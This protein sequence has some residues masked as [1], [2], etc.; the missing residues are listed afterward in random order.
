MHSEKE[1]SR[2]PFEGDP[3]RR[4]AETLGERLLPDHPSE[5]ACE[6]AVSFTAYQHRVAAARK[7]SLPWTELG[8]KPLA[9]RLGVDTEVSGRARGVAFSRFDPDRIYLA[10]A[11]GG[12][13]RSDDRG[14][15]WVFTMETFD[16]N[17]LHPGADSLSC[18]ALAVAPQ[19]PDRVYV[20]TGEASTGVSLGIGPLVSYVGG[21]PSSGQDVVWQVEPSLPSLEGQG[22]FQ[23]AV[24]PDDVDL[25]VGAT[26]GGLYQRAVDAGSAS[27]HRV[28]PGPFTSVV[29]GR[30]RDGTVVFLAAAQGGGVFAADSNNVADPDAWS[31]L[32]T[33]F[34]TDN[35]GRISL[36]LAG[37]EVDTVFALAA[38]EPGGFHGVYRLLLADGNWRRLA[39]A[40]QELFTG[41]G[42]WAQA[43]TLDPSDPDVFYLGGSTV[44]IDGFDLGALYRCQLGSDGETMSFTFIGYGVH[45]DIQA[46]AFTP[47]PAKHLW[48]AC[49]GGVFV[50]E[51][52]AAVGQVFASRN[53]TLG[54]IT[55]NHLAQHPTGDELYCGSHDNGLVR[56]RGDQRWETV[57]PSDCSHAVVHWADPGRV[58]AAV[59]E[60]RLALHREGQPT[61]FNL[62]LPLERDEA[63]PFNV[64]LAGTP[65]P[66]S[67]TPA[68]L[69]QADRVAA[70]SIRPWISEQFGKDGS[71]V[72]IPTLTLEGDE[73]DSLICSLRFASHLILYAG[74][75]FGGVYRFDFDPQSESW[76]RKAL[77]AP[78]AP[79]YFRAPITDI[80]ADPADP[81]G[82]SIYVTL[83]GS[84]EVA[85]RPD[86]RRL[87]HYD[88]TTGTWQP[89]SG[90]EQDPGHQL[91]PVRHHAVAVDPQQ[92]QRL[93]VGADIGVWV[94]EDGGAHWEPC[95]TALPDASVVD[96]DFHPTLR[97]LRASTHGRGCFELEVPP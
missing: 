25:V 58:L 97:L 27:W 68:L 91:L 29:A 71:W 57:F 63:V 21:V 39:G 14:V 7:P 10:A 74:T 65:P 48:V 9:Q 67:L 62:S 47:G 70:G 20:G 26:T 69:H 40:P 56:Y 11:N 84:L 45:A 13:W 77:A 15:N 35:L 94:S 55:L 23:L 31:E 37:D 49:D 12:V 85:G 8:P 6:R 80:A 60:G 2:K 43:I 87:W 3:L 38:I 50:A 61:D 96:L 72:S 22:F 64:P 93:W 28:L 66:P 16:L 90:P 95:Q 86:Y 33:G 5:T 44:E 46:L 82:A 88:G 19:D 1:P 73:L 79:V 4:S 30:R 89:R 36:A 59:Y 53:A 32:G 41:F 81:S 42:Q 17:P 54:T 52:P 83:G 18:G 75:E 34:P 92:P 76:S 51:D 78:L 24:S